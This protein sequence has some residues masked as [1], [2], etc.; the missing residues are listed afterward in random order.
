M[1]NKT[2][3]RWVERAQVQPLF[4]PAVIPLLALYQLIRAFYRATVLAARGV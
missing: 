4:A 1:I 3:L 2:A